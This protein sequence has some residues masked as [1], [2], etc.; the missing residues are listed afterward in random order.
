MNGFASCVIIQR[1]YLLMP[2]ASWG[3]R[4]RSPYCF[5]PQTAYA[6][7]RMIGWEAPCTCIAM[8]HIVWLAERPRAPAF[9][10]IPF[11]D[12]LRA[13]VHLHCDVTIGTETITTGC[14]CRSFKGDSPD[15]KGH[16][17]I[18]WPIWGRQDP[19]GPHVGPMNFAIWVAMFK[20]KKSTLKRNLNVVK[21]MSIATGRSSGVTLIARLMGPTWGPS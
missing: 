14:S 4:H 19:G 16:W 9:W 20:E 7:Q 3:F 12:L 10:C 15:G 6:L 8:H 5:H 17:A 1:F 11:Y 18:M 13:L 2:V 21:S